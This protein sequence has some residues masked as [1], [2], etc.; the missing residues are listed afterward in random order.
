MRNKIAGG[1]HIKYD[2]S[3]V[4]KLCS[5]KKIRRDKLNQINKNEK[6]SKNS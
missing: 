4:I 3:V 2:V 1:K 6:P 5:I